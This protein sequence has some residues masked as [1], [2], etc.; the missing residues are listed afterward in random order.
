MKKL[1]LYRLKKGLESVG[2]L[3]GIKFAYTIAKNLRKVAAEV[4]ILD[5][6]LAPSEAFTKYEACHLALCIEHS[7]KDEAGKPRGVN[8]P[9]G[10]FTFALADRAAFE[11]AMEEVRAVHEKAIE[12]R[13]DQVQ[14]HKE[15]LREPAEIDLYLIDLD[16]IPEAITTEQ[17]TAILEI[18]REEKQ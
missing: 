5:E 2:G 12:D 6:L 8:E 11:A 3:T 13:K 14:R 16:V 1:D 10:T 17:M 7:E 18:V 15:F 4:S 9:N